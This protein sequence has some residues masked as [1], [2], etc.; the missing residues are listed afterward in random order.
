MGEGSIKRPITESK[1]K[2]FLDT[3]PQPSITFNSWDIQVII[4]TPIEK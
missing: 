3:T 4:S 2:T 1:K